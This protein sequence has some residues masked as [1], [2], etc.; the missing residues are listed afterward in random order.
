MS[1]TLQEMEAQFEALRAAIEREK[2]KVGSQRVQSIVALVESMS[3]PE[4]E[5]VD[6]CVQVV[7][8]LVRML[9]ATYEDL[10]PALPTPSTQVPVEARPSHPSRGRKV[11]VKYRDSATGHTWAGRGLRPHWLQER[12]SEGLRLEDFSCDAVLR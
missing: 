4:P 11:P 7:R 5:R 2:K 10:A 9:G 1:T 3:V 6:L 8:E 12:L